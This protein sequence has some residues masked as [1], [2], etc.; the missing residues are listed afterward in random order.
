MKE[1]Y[2]VDI[3]EKILDF[4][5]LFKKCCISYTHCLFKNIINNQYFAQLFKLFFKSIR[6]GGNQH[7]ILRKFKVMRSNSQLYLSKIQKMAEEIL[8]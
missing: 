2:D 3:N 8:G 5:E 6:S 7:K 4:A 1:R